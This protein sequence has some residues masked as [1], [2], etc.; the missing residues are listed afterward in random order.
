MSVADTL[1]AGMA[2]VFSVLPREQASEGSREVLERYMARQAFGETELPWVDL[3]R[4]GRFVRGGITYPN[5]LST[6]FVAAPSDHPDILALL[7]SLGDAPPEPGRIAHVGGSDRFH[8]YVP[9]AFPSAERMRGAQ[10]RGLVVSFALLA[11]V[12]ELFDADRGTTRAEK[13]LL[14]Q[15]VCG[16]T[17]REAAD[18]D[19]LSFETKRA[20]VKSLSAKLGCRGQTEL[21]RRTMG[22]L[23]QL[24]NFLADGDSPYARTTET[25]VRQHLP[26]GVRLIINRL[27]GDRLLRTLECGPPD[28]RPVL[29]AHG[30]LYP[31]LFINGVAECERLGIRLIMPVRSGYLDDQSAAALYGESDATRDLDDVAI[32]VSRF[33][34][35]AL[36]IVG[37]SM[38]ASWALRFGRRHP[39]RV[40]SL[41]L[42]SP[43]F[44]GDRHG[45]SRFAVFLGGLKSLADRP[46][47]F[48]YVAW[49]FRKYYVDT[50][51][52]E[53]VLRRL[54]EDSKDDLAVLA[55]ERGGGPAY[56]WFAASY[57]SSIVG[58]AE[59]MAA[60]MQNSQAE[61]A[62]LPSP[63]TIIYGPDDPLAMF[64]EHVQTSPSPPRAVLRRLRKG[65]HLVVASHAKE[66]WDTL[67][68]VLEDDASRR[69][70]PR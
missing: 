50:R 11:E 62:A 56:P 5:D 54:F 23:I 38:G 15:L 3:D 29:F 52:V 4:T 48:R 46:G 37:H 64:V 33:E 28:G 17:L 34:G 36:P 12:V 51:M 65:G 60:S 27:A 6:R 16:A 59:D 67:S 43:H 57:R 22:Q 9:L 32:F 63:T 68:S 8:W 70:A 30:M 61:L 31:L 44:A 20:Q 39:A 40:A 13:R 66:V 18:A 19:G 35:G 53:R 42:L 24:L 14:F 49:Q 58:I 41:V 25:F 69:P 47:L 45:T 10:T 7:D 21:V 2:S 26:S 55:G 1:T